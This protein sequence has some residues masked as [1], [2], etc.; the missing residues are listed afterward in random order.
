MVWLEES[1]FLVRLF[2]ENRHISKEIVQQFHVLAMPAAHNFLHLYPD[3]VVLVMDPDIEDQLL[4]FNLKQL[5]NNLKK[6]LNE[7]PES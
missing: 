4:E 2:Y 1:V 6:S 7:L 3:E 5:T